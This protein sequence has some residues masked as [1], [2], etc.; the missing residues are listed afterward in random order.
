MRTVVM[1]AAMVAVLAAFVVVDADARLANSWLDIRVSGHLLIETSD[2][3]F[4]ISNDGGR[5]AVIDYS[6]PAR[7]QQI[8]SNFDDVVDGSYVIVFER[9]GSEYMIV[10]SSEGR[11]IRIIDITNI[12]RPE[13]LSTAAYGDAGFDSLVYGAGKAAIVETD[14]RTYAMMVADGGIL[15]VEITD[16]TNIVPVSY[17]EYASIED[18]FSRASR[19]MT[20]AEVAGRTYLFTAT[21]G[22]GGTPAV[23]VT[24]PRNMQAANAPIF[25]I[26]EGDYRTTPSGRGLD[27]ANAFAWI[28]S[29]GTFT[30]DAGSTYA[31]TASSYKSLNIFNITDP[32][33]ITETSKT[34][35]DERTGR[36]KILEQGDSTYA[37]L[38]TA[39]NIRTFDVTDPYNPVSLAVFA[40]DKYDFGIQMFD[41]VDISGMPHLLHASNSGFVYA[42]DLSDPANPVEITPAI[43]GGFYAV[44]EL[45]DVVVT[46]IGGST[47]VLAVG[48]DEGG[49]M[50]VIKI[51]EHGQVEAVAAMFRGMNGFGS[52][53]KAWGID[54]ARINGVPYAVVAGERD[55]GSVMIID[56]SDPTRPES[57]SSIF[58]DDNG[59]D[60]LGDPW[61][62]A[63]AEI[64][65]RH[66]AITASRG[67]N[68]VQLIDITD[69]SSPRPAGYVAAER[70]VETPTTQEEI[71]EWIADW[72][73][74]D[75]LK[76]WPQYLK[77]V[78]QEGRTYVVVLAARDDYVQMID[79]TNPD[80]PK[81]AGST[82]VLGATSIDT[83]IM[84]GRTFAL[85]AG[86]ADDGGGKLTILE[87]NAGSISYASKLPVPW[88][89][90]DPILA[91][92]FGTGAA[93]DGG[94][95]LYVDGS[96][97]YI[98][99]ISDP[100]S[101]RLGDYSAQQGGDA[102]VHAVGDLTYMMT[103]SSHGLGISEM[104]EY[105]DIYRLGGFNDGRV[106]AI[107]DP[108]TAVTAIF[109]DR[110]GFETLAGANSIA[111]IRTHEGAYILAGGSEGIQVINVDDPYHPSPATAITNITVLDMQ[112][113]NDRYLVAE[114]I[115]GVMAFNVT[116][117]ASPVQIV[118][119]TGLTDIS[120]DDVQR[121][122]SDV[123][124]L[125]GE[126]RIASVYSDGS[127]K[128]A[129][130]FDIDTQR[131]NSLLAVENATSAAL[132]RIGGTDY[133]MVAVVGHY[134]NSDYDILYEQKSGNLLVYD[135]TD[136]HNI[137]KLASLLETRYGTFVLDPQH[138]ETFKVADRHYA[139]GMNA[140]S[141]YIVDVT[142]PLNPAVTNGGGGDDNHNFRALA[143]ASD[144]DIMVIDGR[145][146]GMV[147][148]PDD[149]GIQIMDITYLALR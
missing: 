88:N 108:I 104:N 77:V 32:A 34:Y 37:V 95:A 49:A 68:A 43:A 118:V 31:V 113:V 59:F 52:L 56:V 8:V 74:S 148:A 39:D 99:D 38:K 9:D 130:G 61:D 117:P 101:P 27:S 22:Y 16:L 55:G 126:S 67:D 78:Y 111:A 25:H 89:N 96:G 1:M 84:D 136:P 44:G 122:D 65:G 134:P 24:D 73:N 131:L 75:G 124:Y 109:D 17:L 48:H 62:V 47:Y 2:T 4:V 125:S 115:D 30:D 26:E 139:I 5:Y 141:F 105:G 3:P 97:S 72:G 121:M 138:L 102:V 110:G 45:R 114:T 129:R 85:V 11:S 71:D 53:Y 42:H 145:L 14:G 112:L 28:E 10:A 80:N 79:I 57:V 23:D 6:N 19:D 36:L 98:I 76:L 93:A 143:G 18:R 12:N 90:V 86:N 51:H 132:A 120:G 142:D 107:S 70:K 92:G 60:H 13:V 123:I 144:F 54:T 106:T 94:T 29:I 127:I 33:N 149:D 58:D 20:M 135:T 87:M 40:P 46:T 91:A 66:Y 7:P 103:F 69:P 83:T 21:N 35:L 116:N 128:V 100:Y 82:R 41:V 64:G 140:Y 119:N 133:G 147:A 137:V 15:A 146:Y 81:V 63:T 50:Q